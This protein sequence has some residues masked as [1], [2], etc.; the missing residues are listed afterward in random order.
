MSEEPEDHPS[1]LRMMGLVALGVAVTILIF[2]GIGY[3][4]GRLFL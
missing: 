3:V 4:L 1:F 2:F